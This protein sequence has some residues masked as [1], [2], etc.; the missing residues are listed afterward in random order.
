MHKLKNIYRSRSTNFWSLELSYGLHFIAISISA[1]FI[2]ILMLELG[3]SLQEVIFYY[4]LLHGL[5]VLFH[6]P[7]KK[8]L[9]KQG[10][11]RTLIAGTIF[12][13]LF[14]ITYIFLEDKN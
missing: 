8:F 14:F 6:I 12:A 11:K 4:V 9:E 3:F 5:N 1:I 7:S 2:P 10:L 13:G